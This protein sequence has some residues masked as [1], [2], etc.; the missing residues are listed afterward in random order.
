MRSFRGSKYQRA[1]VSRMET[2]CIQRHQYVIS[3]HTR[4]DVIVLRWTN[5]GGHGVLVEPFTLVLKPA[6]LTGSQFTV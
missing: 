1:D 3:A 5:A 6:T 2:G 4:M